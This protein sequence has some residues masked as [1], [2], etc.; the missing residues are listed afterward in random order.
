MSQENV[1]LVRKVYEGWSRGDFAAGADVLAADF[2]WR[3]HTEAVEPGARRGDA[4]GDSLRKIFDIYEDFRVDPEEF[5]DAGDRVVVVGRVRGT[6]RRMGIDLD[7][8]WAF[9]WTAREGRL[10]RNE[11]Y[12]NRRDALKAAGLSE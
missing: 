3:Q 6:Q 4:V 12:R 5:I 1:E 11:V 10:V 9:V 2:E 8:K 7:E